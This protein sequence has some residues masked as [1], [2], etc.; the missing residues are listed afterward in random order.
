MPLH[1]PPVPTQAELYTVPLLGLLVDDITVARSHQ[2][3]IWVCVQAAGHPYYRESS[4]KAEGRT[5]CDL[6]ALI[7]DIGGS[8]WLSGLAFVWESFSVHFQS[9]PQQ[10][11]AQGGL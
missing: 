9:S 5:F 4:H 6:K 10:P 8:Q 11:W 2:E 7:L 1:Q 3:N